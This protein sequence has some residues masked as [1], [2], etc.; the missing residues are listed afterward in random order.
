LSRFCALSVPFFPDFSSK[1]A[2]IATFA[3]HGSGDRANCKKYFWQVL[4]QSDRTLYGGRKSF[5]QRM[6]TPPQQQ[7]P[8]KVLILTVG[9][10]CS[11]K[12]YWARSTG[13]P[14]VNP[15]SIRLT[16]HGQAFIRE[17]EPMIWT[18][19]R[20][21]VGSLFTAGHDVVILDAC[22]YGKKFRD[23]WYNPSKWVCKFKVFNTP[24]EVC[25]ERAAREKPD[26]TP[27]IQSQA[28]QFEPLSAFESQHELKLGDLSGRAVDAIAY[29]AEPESRS[30]N[31]LKKLVLPESS[32]ISKKNERPY[33]K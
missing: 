25:L 8:E 5:Y 21:M 3:A 4:L 19:A 30:R 16:L 7:Q 33:T 32:S 11:G 31:S 24:L 15:D 12:S 23:D 18:M 27:I 17:A 9:V 10:P 26:L 22:N 28:K 29:A 13:L 1:T 6:N 14:M 20:Y 2:R